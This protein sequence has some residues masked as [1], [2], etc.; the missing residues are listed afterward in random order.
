MDLVGCFGA[1][2]LSLSGGMDD[3]KLA[4]DGQL[5]ASLRRLA[6]MLGL[7]RGNLSA[8]F[9]RCYKAAQAVFQKKRCSRQ[10]AWATAFRIV[11]GSR[12]QSQMP[13]L[14]HVLQRYLG[15]GISTSGVEHGFARMR[16]LLEHRGSSTDDAKAHWMVLSEAFDNSNESDLI[17]AQAQEFWCENYRIAR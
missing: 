1:F 6:N 5:A 3:E 11:T 2:D 4:A 14:G 15:W 16:R 10:E 13:A 17:V 7:N 8:D 12:G 9:A